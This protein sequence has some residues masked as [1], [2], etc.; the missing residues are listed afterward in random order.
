MGGGK[1]K[2]V[3]RKVITGHADPTNPRC[4]VKLFKTYSS[5]FQQ[6]EKFYK[7]PLSFVKMSGKP[8]FSKQNVG[9][10]TPKKYMKRMFT[11]AGID[12]SDRNITNHP[13]KVTLWTTLFNSG[14]IRWCRTDLDIARMQKCLQTSWGCHAGIP[15]PTT[16]QGLKSL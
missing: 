9:Y 14:K 12:T 13:G 3:P 2:R 4:V 15:R 1:L 11:A 7:R 8:R 10:D 6:N 16:K 5:C